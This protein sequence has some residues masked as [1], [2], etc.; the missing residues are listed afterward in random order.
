M[1]LGELAKQLG[2]GL[3]D[4]AAANVEITGVRGLEQ[5]AGGH[6][7]FLSN[8]KYAPKLKTTQA[9]AV[10]AGQPAPGIATL[11]SKNPYHDYARALELFYQPPR[12][13][14]GV[15]SSAAISATAVIGDGASIGAF[16]AI[17]ENVVIGRNA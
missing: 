2:C 9:S 6:V 12:P 5:A 17:G 13:K 8:P 4:S 1:K 14:P 3:S 16:V 15:H 7:T 10:I 11:I